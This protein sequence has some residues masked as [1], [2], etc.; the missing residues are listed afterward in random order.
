MDYKSDVLN[1][2][3]DKYENRVP[4]SNRRVRVI[5]RN[6]EVQIPDIEDEDYRDF[7][8]DMLYLKSK[9]FIDFD[10]VRKDYI[11]GS[12]WLNLSNA[13]TVFHYL[14]REKRASRVDDVAKLIDTAVSEVRT[15]WIY[16]FLKSSREYMLAVNKLTGIWS[17]NNELITAFL[18]ALSSIDRI[19]STVSMRAFSVKVYGDSK[20]FERDIKQY[21]IPVIK[22]NEPNLADVEE[23]SD[24]EVLAQVGII[25]MPEI[26]EF[27]GNVSICFTGGT[28]DFS[29]ISKGAC[30]SSETVSDI[31]YINVFET[32]RIIFIENKTNYSEY[33]LNNKTDRELVVYHGGF[34]SPQRGDFFRKLCSGNNIP[35][36]FWGDI[37]YGGFK[38][39]VRLKN[40]IINRLQPLNMDI[41][42]Y[43]LY[44]SKG[45]KKNDDYITKLLALTE[46]PDYYIFRDVIGAI[47]DEK[48]T[49]EQESFLEK[50]LAS[51]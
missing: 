34:Y 42:C 22:N 23:I 2:L 15:H 20:K 11:I 16:T 30:I 40:N 48:I 8:D 19:E 43:N 26:F 35:A 9:G 25:M 51:V 46:N 6:N 29:P 44:K 36:Y 32:D 28:V 41:C 39:F 12:I 21:I 14:E 17:K 13:D 1:K 3:L 10:W 49:V 18:D 37:D 27:C 33:C 4:G 5:C 38:M 31:K 24:R 50:G 47:V 7:R 45:L